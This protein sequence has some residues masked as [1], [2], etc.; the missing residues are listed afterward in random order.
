MGRNMTRATGRGL[1]SRKKVTLAIGRNVAECSIPWISAGTVKGSE[2]E[3]LVRL[4][5]FCAESAG[6][7]S[8]RIFSIGWRR[9]SDAGKRIVVCA[10]LF[11]KIM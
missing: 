6:S 3:R 7:V 2:V 8:D 9:I 10:D 11:T 5:F 4:D 1:I